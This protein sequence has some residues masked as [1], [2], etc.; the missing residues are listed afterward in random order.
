MELSSAQ[1]GIVKAVAEFS[2]VERYQGAMPRRHT[3]LYDERDIKEL[4]HADF[5]EWI[6]LTFSCGK[7]LKG[8]RLTDAGRRMLSGGRVPGADST[9]LEPEHLDVL[10][11]TYH[12]SK[13][14]RYRGI[15]PEKKARF[16]DPDDVA[17][18]FARGYLLRVRIKWGEGRKAKGYIVSTK[19]LR[20]LRETG[21]L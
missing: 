2:A 1:H 17:D 20:A 12:L 3:F 13:T 11:D 9:G 6:K 19:G 7:G 10:G 8:L 16:Y 18:L 15:M 14:S 4:V 5:L 21:R